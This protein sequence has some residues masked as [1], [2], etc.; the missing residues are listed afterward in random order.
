MKFL[1]KPYIGAGKILLGMTSSQIE[2]ALKTK[3]RKFKK[4]R[5]DEFET[6]AFEMCYVY[7]KEPGICEAIEFFKPA[8]VIFSGLN[9]L[10]S[11]YDDIE[12]LFLTLD[13]KTVLDDTGLISYKY[14]ICVY[15]TFS[16]D[17]SSK[18]VEGVIVFE[19]GYY[20]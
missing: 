4:L 2:H 9:L 20:D 7:Y 6:D 5:S 10:D 11:H 3:S 12:N 15:A 16:D 14:G 19:R 18:Q 1:I 8:I 17:G 13:E